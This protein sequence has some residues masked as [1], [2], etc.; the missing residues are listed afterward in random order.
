MISEIVQ[1]ISR[2]GS[3]WFSSKSP[4]AGGE[5]GLWI[6]K[7]LFRRQSKVPEDD[8]FRYMWERECIGDGLRGQ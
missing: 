6:E 1:L 4:K 2:N 5:W 8:R 3:A 7:H